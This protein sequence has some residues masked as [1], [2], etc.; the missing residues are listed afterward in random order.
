MNA[1]IILGMVFLMLVVGW[2]AI[3]LGYGAEVITLPDVGEPGT[4]PWWSSIPVIGGLLQADTW[5]VNSVGTF[6]ALMTFQV[7]GIPAMVNMFLFVPFS[8]M[9]LWM[10]FNAVRGNG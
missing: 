6:V 8:L 5:I 4:Q 2:L 3:Q 7:E 10:V 9:L 1:K